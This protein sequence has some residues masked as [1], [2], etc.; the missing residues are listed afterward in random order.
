MRTKSAVRILLASGD[1][2]LQRSISDRLEADSDRFT[3]SQERTTTAALDSL[4]HGDPD[5]VVGQHDPGTV[6][7]LEILEAV[8]EDRGWDRPFLVV[9]GGDD[10]AVAVDALNLGADRYV[11]AV[12]A[13]SETADRVASAVRGTVEDHPDEPPEKSQSDLLFENNPIVVWEQDYSAVKRRLDSIDGDPIAYLD[14]NPEATGYLLNEIDVIDINRT[15]LEHY[16]ADSKAE[17]LEDMQQLFTERSYEANRE[18]LKRIA[19][20]ETNFRTESVTRTLEGERIH[21]LIEFRVPEAYAE[22]YS[23]VFVTAIDITERKASERELER[24]STRFQALANNPDL[25]VITV[26]AESRIRYASEGVRSIF[27]YVA[28]ELEGRSLEVIMPDRYRDDHRT[29]VDRYVQTDET[30]L[31]WEWTELQGLHADGHEV[32]IGVSFGKGSIRGDVRITGVV[33]DLTERNTRESELQRF[34]RASEAAGHAIII[35]DD[36]GT[37]EYV[38]PAFERITGY[39]SEEAVG[40]SPRILKSGEM[41][42]EFYE[43]LWETI[44]RGETWEDVI[45]NRR[46]SGGLYHAQQTIA[47]ITDEEGTVE[48]FVAIQTDVTDRVERERHLQVLDRFL[49]H[50]LRNDMTVVLGQAETILEDPTADV[51]RAARQILETGRGLVELA[52]GERRIVELLTDRPQPEPIPLEPTLEDVVTRVREEFPR[53]EITADCPDGLVVTAVRPIDDALYELVKNGIEHNDRAVPTVDISAKRDGDVVH[54]CVADDGGGIPSTER[55]VMTGEREIRPLFHGSGLGLWIVYHVVKLSNGSLR[56]D[57][58]E[59][60]GSR[61]TVTFPTG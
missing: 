1:P 43:T 21:E 18:I 29:V 57:E 50:N 9:G 46:K 49:R 23:R 42:D 38:N 8:R 52:D 12:D 40:R 7:A 41:S 44:C 24:M 47:P 2:E 34:R 28:E 13:P 54:V 60:R 51:E 32:P 37:I 22:D 19:A 17:L 55:Q 59:G 15:A 26:D 36:E 53:S 27:G 61:V 35:T 16:G 20:G 4:R 31:D 3:V 45:V 39:S 30:D 48:E 56:F 10:A 33:R 6:D 25:G 5:C 58:N 14:D 11:E